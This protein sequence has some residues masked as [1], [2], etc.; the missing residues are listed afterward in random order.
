MRLLI[1][2]DG[3]ARGGGTENRIRLLLEEFGKREL[4]EEIHILYHKDYAQPPLDS[5]TSHMGDANEASNYKLV[6]SILF[7]H[8]IDI[9][10]SHNMVAITPFCLSA[11]F[12][13]K[14]PVI[15]FAHDYWPLCAKRSFIDPYKAREKELCKKATFS[16]CVSCVGLRTWMRLKSFRY[17]LK[18]VNIAISACNFVKAV[19]ES[20][21]FLKGRWK[22]IKPW[23][24]LS[25]FLFNPHSVRDKSILFTGSLIDYKGA[26]V[27]A[28]AFAG[29]LKEVPDA[30]LKFV[31]SE[32]E[33][34][35]RYRK[36]LERIFARDG[37][38]NH[39]EFLGYMDWDK[40]GDQYR[41]AGVYVCPTV[42]LE[43]F[44]LNWAEALA[45][46]CPVVA[47]RVG[48]IPE[49]TNNFGKLVEPA[50]PRAL[51][52]SI[53][54]VLR[55]KRHYTKLSE[56]GAAYVKNTFNVSRAASEMIALYRQLLDR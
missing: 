43:S 16:N 10:Q 3:G 35:N 14:I 17:F 4:F 2:N 25:K 47:S 29:V 18:N 30:K 39:V 26:W 44:G 46:G 54:T 52:D 6:K 33:P 12:K 9:V 24:E 27:L 5:V 40:L 51:A 23:I 8:K 38:I 1:I 21:N 32:Q 15:W 28:E 7:E 53:V 56:E 55:N 11:A 50:D 41:T 42:C 13:K 48:S 22:V 31:G 49:T 36:R 37:T 20:H 34:D 45:T 19:Y